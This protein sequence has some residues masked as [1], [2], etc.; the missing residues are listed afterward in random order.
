MDIKE[1]MEKLPF[2]NKLSG[3]EKEFIFQSAAQR[4]FEKEAGI[5][6]FADACL[7]MIYVVKGSIRVYIIS[8]EGREITLFHIEAGNCCILSASCV[9]DDIGLDVQL[10]TETETEILTIH[11][12]AVDRLMN[13][14]IEFKCFVYELSTNRLASVVR[15]INEILFDHFDVRLARVLIGFYK[16]NGKKNIKITQE[17]LAQEVNSAREVVARMLKTFAKEGWIELKRGNILLKDIEALT[18]LAER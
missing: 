13:Q 4:S 5:N 10:M 15:V 12:G 7:G 17:S 9:M 16:K 2:I 1:N 18:E 11:A 14:N 3:T 6:A 8:E